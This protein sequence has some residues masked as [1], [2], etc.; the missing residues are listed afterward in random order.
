MKLPITRKQIIFSNSDKSLG[1]FLD[2]IETRPSISDGMWNKLY[3]I[4]AISRSFY[5]EPYWI[6]RGTAYQ[7][8][9]TNRK[10]EAIM[11]EDGLS[12]G[13]MIKSKRK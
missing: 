12:I 13:E 3:A 5:K 10:V 9:V 6:Y 11:H 2:A 7:Y 8:D 4:L 1:S